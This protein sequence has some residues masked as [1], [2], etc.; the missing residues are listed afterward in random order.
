MSQ[1]QAVEHV[2]P[3]NVVPLGS[4]QD[5]REFQVIQRRA[6]TLAKSGLVPK[7]LMGK[8]D[9]IIVIALTGRDMGIPMMQ[10]LSQ[11]YVI[12]GRPS[13]S[14]QLML[15]LARRHGHDIWIEESTEET[16]TAVGTRRGSTKEQRLTW[17]IGMA[18]GA[19]LL[20]KDNWKKYPAAMLRARAISNLCR[21]VCPD[22][23]LGLEDMTPDELGVDDGGDDTHEI[24]EAPLVEQ[25]ELVDA[26]EVVEAAESSDGVVSSPPSTGDHSPPPPEP[27]DAFSEADQTLAGAS[28]VQRF[29]KAC[30]E[31]GMSDDERHALIAHATGGRTS[32]AKGVL[33]EEV[34][35]LQRWFK[36]I[37]EERYGFKDEGGSIV[38]VKIEQPEYSPG[39]EPF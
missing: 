26:P 34:E 24:L 21:V 19:G 32:S 2:R 16:C 14:A 3:E 6:Q 33:K 12:E 30:R 22:A 13:P 1:S 29:A 31:A 7:A 8:P 37:T 38:V 23:L 9:D 17:T 11:I 18:R 4:T 36:A 27:D 25:T 35:L 28:F 10:A 5:E 20:N 15:G 39:E